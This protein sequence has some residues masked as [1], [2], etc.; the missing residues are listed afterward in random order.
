MM[1]VHETSNFHLTR[2]RRPWTPPAVPV[3]QMMLSALGGWLEEP[4]RVPHPPDG[5]LTIEEWKH[6]AGMG[7]DHEVKVVY[8]GFLCPSATGRRWS[9]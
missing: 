7:R 2:Q 9:S 5:P 1:L 3:E 8:A 4:R 6:R